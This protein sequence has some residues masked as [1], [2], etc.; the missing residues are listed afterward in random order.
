MTSISI[1]HFHSFFLKGI[2]QF[3]ILLWFHFQL[4]INVYFVDMYRLL[5]LI[6][7]L[8]CCFTPCLFVQLALLVLVQHLIVVGNHRLWLILVQLSNEVICQFKS[9]L[10]HVSHTIDA[11]QCL[12]LVVSLIHLDI[13]ITFFRHEQ[14]S[15]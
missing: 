10:L 7:L 11:H 3:N 14:V 12:F 4:H 6:E 13:S 15:K 5:N 8:L 2:L 1:G 9:D